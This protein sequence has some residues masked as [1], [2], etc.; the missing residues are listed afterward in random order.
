[1]KESVLS[2]EE[3]TTNLGFPTFK[4]SASTKNILRQLPIKYY[5]WRFQYTIIRI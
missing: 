5:F 3:K 1:M 4:L 2:F